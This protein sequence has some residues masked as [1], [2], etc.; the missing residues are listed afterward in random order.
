MAHGWAKFVNIL[1]P[2]KSKINN[3]PKWLE[4]IK[5]SI[6]LYCNQ[7]QYAILISDIKY[8]LFAFYKCMQTVQW[9][10]SFE[11]RRTYRPISLTCVLCKVLEHNIASGLSKH[12]YYLNI[13]Y[14]LQHGFQEKNNNKKQK[15]KKKKKKKKKTDPARQSWW[16]QLI[17]ELVKTTETSLSLW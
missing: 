3:D 15:K 5:Y 4:N 7:N 16:C 2:N 8:Q 6:K 12:F 1:S 11:G 10:S 14:E 13:L 9:H 17:E